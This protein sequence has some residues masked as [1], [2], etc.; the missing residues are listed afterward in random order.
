MNGTVL[1][2]NPSVMTLNM[3]RDPALKWYPV[4]GIPINTSTRAI[5]PS[6]SPLPAKQSVKPIST[7][8]FSSRETTLFR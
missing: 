6:I 8:S 5:S 2:P 7:I 3:V 1:I 4:I